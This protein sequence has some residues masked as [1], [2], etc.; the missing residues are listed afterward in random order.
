MRINNLIR[1]L[2]VFIFLCVPAASW[3][4][5]VTLRWQANSEPD[6]AGYN[7]YYGTAS[8]AYGPPLPASK[9]TSYTVDNLVE[10]RTYYFAL[11]ALDTSGNESGYSSE[12]SATATSFQKSSASALSLP[13][14]AWL[15]MIPGGDQSHFD[16]V[17]FTFPGKSGNVGLLYEVWDID[18]NNEVQVLL[19]GKPIAYV[20]VTP[21]NQW[22]GVKSL[23]LP[24]SAVLNT[25]EN[26]LVF[27]ATYNPP[28]KWHWGV[29]KV[30]IDE[31]AAA[32]SGIPADAVSL[33]STAWLGMIPGG[34][35]SH[36]D[37]ATFTFPAKSGNVTLRYEAWDID[38]NNEVQVLLNG[39]PIANVPVTPNNQW[40][41]VKSLLLPDSAVSNTQENI[42]VFKATYNPPNKWHWGVR[43]VEVN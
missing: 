9:A 11:T 2:L 31:G 3:A 26:I 13:S 18:M 28:N 34:D 35:Q 32:S 37:K 10:G 24:D 38:M 12:I 42:L 23:L 27:K 1:Y 5:S 7:L 6:I 8:R 21:N 22:G 20:P 39:K 30:S 19:N 36:F 29:R 16:K 4:A 40:G 41:G 14:T 17:T 25:Q 33:P 15:G 43:R